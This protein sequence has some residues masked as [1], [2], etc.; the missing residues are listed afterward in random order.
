MYYIGLDVHRKNDRLLREGRQ[1]SCL[2]SR[3]DTCHMISGGH[4]DEKKRP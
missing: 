1:W 2:R 4:F 3:F